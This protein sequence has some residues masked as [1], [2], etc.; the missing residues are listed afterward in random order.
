MRPIER[1]ALYA[2]WILLLTGSPSG[3]DHRTY[4]TASDEGSSLNSLHDAHRWLE[5]RDALQKVKGPALYRGVV[6]AAL[7]DR[8]EAEKILRRVIKSAPRS[9]QAY[10]AYEA[11][12][13]LYIQ[14][15]QYRKLSSV[16]EERLA[17]FPEKKE[18]KQER[19]ALAPFLDLPDQ[20]TDKSR[21]SSLRHDGSLFVPLSINGK[22]TSYFLD[23][24]AGANAMSESDAKR[25]GLEVHQEVGHM[26]TATTHKA[27]FR[28]GVA[29]EL[30]VGNT[31]LKNVSFA[32]F[33]DEQ[34]PWSV[35]PPGRRG[36]IGIPVLLALRTL[37]WTQDGTFETGARAGLGDARKP[38]LYFDNDHLVMVVGFQQRELLV[39]LDTGA[40][41]TD[42]HIGFADEFPSLLN[43]LGKKDSTEVKGVGQAERFNSVTLP[44]LTFQVGGSKTVLRP[45]HV[46]LKQL[47]PKCCVGNFGVD[48][49][50]QGHAFKIDFDAMTL[51]LEER[52]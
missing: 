40:E 3:Q 50:K 18:L 33:P 46:I 20:K 11:L 2:L 28:T 17:A 5:L 6:A 41:G 19:I 36:A 30:T 51:R 14:T 47:G 12:S 44:E 24:G 26:G 9:E 52:P 35:L 31:R 29:R 8:S 48:L 37:R 34:E 32:I 39:T 1:T 42:L 23:T 38:N 10:Q 7:I 27:A 49:L 45:A 43:E 25:L 15:G 13:H 22:S 21:P 4:T 16:M